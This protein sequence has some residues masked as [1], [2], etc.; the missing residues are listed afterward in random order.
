MRGPSYSLNMEEVRQCE[1]ITEPNVNTCCQ[2]SIKKRGRYR[3]YHQTMTGSSEIFT[4]YIKK[5]ENSEGG[6]VQT[7]SVL[8]TEMEK[9]LMELRQ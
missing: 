8:T 7:K 6:R 3:K 2:H 4:V 9:K 5:S 1:L